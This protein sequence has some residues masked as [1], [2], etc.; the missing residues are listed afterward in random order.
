MFIYYFIILFCYK[1][2]NGT[3]TRY[4]YTVEATLIRAFA[5]A[6]KDKL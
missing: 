6:F 5:C 4:S 3:V 2:R 1:G